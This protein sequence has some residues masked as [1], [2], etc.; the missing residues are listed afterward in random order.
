MATLLE[1]RKITTIKNLLN[2]RLR[3]LQTINTHTA[4]LEEK[5]QPYR[6]ELETVNRLLVA[7]GA[8]LGNF[9]DEVCEGTCVEPVAGHDSE[10]VPLCQGCLDT[11]RGDQAGEN[12]TATITLVEQENQAAAGATVES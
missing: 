3:A 12:S 6:S 8:D 11:L 10:G 7:E 9:P 1:K 5:L 4:K 2:R